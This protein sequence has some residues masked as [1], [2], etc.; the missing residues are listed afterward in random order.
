MSGPSRK[1]CHDPLVMP[2]VSADPLMMSAMSAGGK[3]AAYMPH[4]AILKLEY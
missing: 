2:A 3:E 4:I 1:E